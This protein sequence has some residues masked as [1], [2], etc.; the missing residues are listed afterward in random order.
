VRSGT[1]AASAEGSPASRASGPFRPPATHR[2]ICGRGG[3]STL[4]QTFAA[5]VIVRNAQQGSVGPVSGRPG[6]ECLELLLKVMGSWFQFLIVR[7][8]LAVGR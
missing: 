7:I 2:R 4:R 1:A 3:R 5:V 6:G 8:Q